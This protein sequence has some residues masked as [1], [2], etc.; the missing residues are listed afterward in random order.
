MQDTEGD[1]GQ[2]KIWELLDNPEK[3]PVMTAVDK[4]ML[5]LGLYRKVK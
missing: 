2:H 3:L 1:T 5:Q 4:L